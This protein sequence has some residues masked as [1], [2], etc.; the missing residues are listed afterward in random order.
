M[1]SKEY[2]I[3]II[4]G[5]PAGL[6]AGLYASRSRFKTL[7][8]EKMGCG[9][10]AAI[11]DWIE[12]F[13]GFPEGISGFDLAQKIEEQAKKFGTE[14]AFDEVTAVSICGESFNVKTQSENIP[15]KAVIMASGANHKKLDIPGESEFSGKGVSYC[16]TC[17]GPFFRGKDVAVI[18][19][20]N[21]AVQE[22]VYLT[23]FAS[24]V[25]IIHRRDRLRA[26]K[27]LQERALNNPKIKMLWNS[28]PVSIHGGELVDGLKI[29][30]VLT[31]EENELPFNGVFVFVGLKPNTAC[32]SKLIQLD[33]SGYIPTDENMSTSVPGIFACGD[34]RKKILRQIV[35]A[36]GEGA[37]AS[38]SAQ[39][40]IDELRGTRYK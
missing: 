20:G 38:F 28:V 11:A 22:A 13:P 36:A 21:S 12:N 23:K 16:A 35:T 14:F 30:N 25:S 10:Q 3:V 6:T 31:S 18:G 8:I 5:G 24:S 27:I 1:Q 2:E 37:L 40:Y 32:V 26:A 17:D 9:G 19:G 39:E 33:E 15:A 7:L 34:A 4:G 29:R